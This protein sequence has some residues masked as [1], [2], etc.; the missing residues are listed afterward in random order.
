MSSCVL[1]QGCK[2]IGGMNPCGLLQGC[3]A[4]ICVMWFAWQPLILSPF[5]ELIFW[6]GN[7]QSTQ[8]VTRLLKLMNLMC[9][10]L[11]AVKP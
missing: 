7:L 4:T 2:A 5:N 9:R 3:E 1:G 8:I 6:V 11:S 10:V